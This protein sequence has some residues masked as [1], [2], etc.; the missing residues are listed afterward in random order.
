MPPRSAAR[1][2]IFPA[3]LAALALATGAAAQTAPRAQVMVLGTPHWDNPGQDYANTQVDDVL[4]ARRQ[5]EIA[6]LA[7]AL[8]GFRPTRIAVE[9]PPAR[10]S[11][12]N[13]RYQ[14]YRRGEA[15]LGRNE[16]DQIGFRLAHMLGHP[17]VYAVD[18]RQDLDVGGVLGWAARNGQADAAQRIGGMIQQLVAGKSAAVADAPL[19]EVLRRENSP[20]ADSLESLYLHFVPIGNDTSFIGA[21]MV[22]SWYARNLKIF[23]NITRVALP[24]ERVLVIMGTGHGPLLRRYVDEHPD[25]DLVHATA[26][27]ERFRPSAPR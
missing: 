18:H 10:D 19:G 20:A 11:A 1:I 8:A 15:A 25:Y 13:A 26:F 5:A 4:S 3:L 2:R 16:I 22:A 21:E 6:A 9:V 27:L 17:R 24:G 12:V 14:A 7:A 23:A